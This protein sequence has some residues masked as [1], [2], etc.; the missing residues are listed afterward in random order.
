MVEQIDDRDQVLIQ[1]LAQGPDALGFA[2]NDLART[3]DQV[4]RT[5]SRSSTHFFPLRIF[6]KSWGKPL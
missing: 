3:G 1:L 5:G 4:F 6:F 2:L